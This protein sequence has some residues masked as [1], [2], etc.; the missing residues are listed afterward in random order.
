MDQRF[1]AEQI[2]GFDTTVQNAVEADRRRVFDYLARGRRAYINVKYRITYRALMTPPFQD[3][4]TRNAIAPGYPVSGPT[5]VEFLGSG[6]YDYVADPGNQQT[7]N[8]IMNM[9][10]ETVVPLILSSE[11]VLPAKEIEIY[12]K[13][14]DSLDWFDSA[15]RSKFIT[16]SDVKF[17]TGQ[18]RALET[19][20]EATYGKMPNESLY[21][22]SAPESYGFHSQ[23]WRT[24]MRTAS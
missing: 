4:Q 6:I 20:I 17:L 16:Q 15:L 24:K 22:L 1:I 3:P 19:V 7:Q 2:E 23:A 9:K 21:G 13:A 12:R 11:I 14:V 18:R 5:E 8:T 10:L